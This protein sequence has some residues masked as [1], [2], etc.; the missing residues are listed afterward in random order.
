MA[1][2]PKQASENQ[3]TMQTFLETFEYS[4]EKH[5][6]VLHFGGRR[7]EREN[8]EN[9]SQPLYRRIIGPEHHHNPIVDVKYQ[10]VFATAED[11]GTKYCTVDSMPGQN[12]KRDEENKCKSGCH[13]F[14]S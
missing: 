12:A 11:G 4:A 1:L 2:R 13:I 8:L 5:T 6:D 10:M 7:E 9:K 14:V 3:R